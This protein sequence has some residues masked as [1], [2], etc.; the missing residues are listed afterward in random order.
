LKAAS[1]TRSGVGRV[2]VPRGATIRAPLRDP[3]MILTGS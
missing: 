2:S 1:R 3:A